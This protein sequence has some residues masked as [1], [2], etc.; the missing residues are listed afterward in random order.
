MLTDY[1]RGAQP[2]EQPLR[3][4]SNR[5]PLGDVQPNQ[6]TRGQ[7]GPKPVVKPVQPAKVDHRQYLCP[8]YAEDVIPYLRSVERSFALEPNFLQEAQV[9]PKH[10][11]I[12]IDWV[13]QVHHRWAWHPES[14]ALAVHLIDQYLAKIPIDRKDMQL[15]SMAA[16]F[17]AGKFEETHLPEMQ[18]FE[19][20]SANSF[21]RD[22]IYKYEQRLLR[23]INFTL[24]RPAPI[25][26]LRAH[27]TELAVPS[28]VHQRAQYLIELCFQ[29]YELCHLLPSHMALVSLALSATLYGHKLNVARFRE[30]VGMTVVAYDAAVAALATAIIDNQNQQRIVGIKNK[31]TEQVYNKVSEFDAATLKEIELT[32]GR[33]I[34]GRFVCTDNVPNIILADANERWKDETSDDP[35]RRIGLVLIARKHLVKIELI[36]CLD[37]DGSD[38]SY[39]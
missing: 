37:S 36:K 17:I 2:T 33:L 28:I 7:S 5:Q 30:E 35:P 16:L 18:E 12:L 22:D 10:R 31:Y 25:T 8:D 9:K 21:T 26:F 39:A 6:E 38:T 32:D 1:N 27:F 14:L 4:T 23:S 3:K 29:T 19:Y 15:L 13:V 11:A 20:M 34:R 24:C